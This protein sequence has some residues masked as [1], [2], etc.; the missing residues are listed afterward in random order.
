MMY[1]KSKEH[2]FFREEA[3]L[4]HNKKALTEKFGTKNGRPVLDSYI[5]L[6]ASF[7]ISNV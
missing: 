6:G 3:R 1:L 5:E 2:L 7:S 4:I